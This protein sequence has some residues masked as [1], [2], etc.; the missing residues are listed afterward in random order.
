MCLIESKKGTKVRKIFMKTGTQ[1]WL[2]LR[3]EG[4]ILEF[5]GFGKK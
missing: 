2:I 3:L 4:M 5:L 1:K